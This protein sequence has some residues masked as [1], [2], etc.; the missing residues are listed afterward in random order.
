MRLRL[1][2]SNFTGPARV[3]THLRPRRRPAV[4]PRRLS[5]AVVIA[6]A[7]T[8]N[9]AVCAAAAQLKVIV[10]GAGMVRSQSNSFYE[11]H[12]FVQFTSCAHPQERIF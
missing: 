12:R 5:A 4:A 7:F 6:V 11:R 10:I 3:M 8:L 2:S 9:A 1:L